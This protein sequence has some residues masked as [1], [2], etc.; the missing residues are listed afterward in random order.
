MTTGF[1]G[2]RIV[3][4]LSGE[5]LPRIAESAHAAHQGEVAARIQAMTHG[6]G[7]VRTTTAEGRY[8]A[9]IRIPLTL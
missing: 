9:V 3:D 6:R 4:W 1:G 7:S 2:R 8:T 5:Q